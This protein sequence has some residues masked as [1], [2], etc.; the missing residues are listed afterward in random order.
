MALSPLNILI[1]GATGNLGS[2]ITRECL[3]R[4]ELIVHTL[5]FDKNQDKCLCDEVAKG[6]GKCI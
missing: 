2:L 3:D 6:G 4:P 1:V 5:V